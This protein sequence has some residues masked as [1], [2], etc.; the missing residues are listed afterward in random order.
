MTYQYY[1]TNF[2]A[3]DLWQVMVA[4]VEASPWHREENVGVHSQMAMDY[5][6]QHFAPWRTAQQNKLA[7]IELC[8]HDAGKPAAEE[9]LEKKDGS[10]VYRRYAGHEQDSA[11]TFTEQWL[12]DPALRALLTEHEARQIRWMIE[13]HLP[14]GLKDAT[15][16]AALRT[17]CAHVMQEYE[18]TFFD[19]LRSDAAGRISDGHEQKLQD[20]EDWIY[21]FQSLAFTPAAKV[22]PFGGTTYILI[23]PSGSG[24]TTWVDQ[25]KRASTRMVS[26]DTYRFAYFYQM[27]PCSDEELGQTIGPEEMKQIYRDAFAYCCEHEKEFKA[28]MD[29]K[30]KNVY[31]DARIGK[32]DIFVDNTNGSRKARARWV[33][34]ARNIGQRVVAVEFWNTFETLLA[35]QKTRGDKEVPYTSLKQ[36]YFAQTCAALGSEVDAVVVVPGI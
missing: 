5:Y 11:V 16:R 27:V 26:M 22:D 17:A 2:K 7:M 23:G 6:E 35:R 18:Q 33:Q 19:C 8:F 36:Q 3:T 32:M 30:V 28:Y 12:K 13:N 1:I 9:V 10:G 15:K 34:E 25:N 29:E 20:V 14:F 31:H 4:T 21:H 24:K